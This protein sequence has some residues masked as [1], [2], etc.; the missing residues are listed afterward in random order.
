M[1]NIKNVIFDFG[2]VLCRYDPD[3]MIS[4]FI[5]DP[6]DIAL[7]KEAMFCRSLWDP[8]DA[9]TITDDEV[10]RIGCG[11]LPERLRAPA[12]AAYD[13]WHENM[14]YVPGMKELTVSLKN[15]GKRLFL[16]SNI[17]IGFSEKW[18][19][20]PALDSLLSPFD[21]LIFS[22]TLGIVK[23][24]PE[25]YHHLIEKYGIYPS[26]SVFIDDR[27]KNVACAESVGIC[28]ILFDGNAE[29][30]SRILFDEKEETVNPGRYRHYKGNDYEVIGLGKHT[31][32][33]EPLVFYRA[34]YGE[35]GLWA[36]PAS[37]WNETVEID[38]R[39]VKRFTYIGPAELTK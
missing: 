5:S 21:G 38:G 12:C 37:M 28:G 6:D 29:K 25:I 23:P 9:G 20:V 7:V 1:K 32:T 34:L 22:G 27:W 3:Y 35:R 2:N 31:E 19:S 11:P 8:L 17:S 13:H 10:K 26:E 39:K 33:G 36:R 16:L 4:R 24:Y 18:K 14:P 15:A 30:L